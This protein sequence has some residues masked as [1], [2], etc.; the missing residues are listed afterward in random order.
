MCCIE[1]SSLFVDIDN[2]EVSVIVENSVNNKLSSLLIQIEDLEISDIGCSVLLIAI[3]LKSLILL[4]ILT[5]MRYL[6]NSV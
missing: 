4:K 3:I 6:V 1:V 2:S 5:I